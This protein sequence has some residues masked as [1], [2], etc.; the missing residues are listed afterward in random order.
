M[1]G[2][3]RIN[4]AQ[5]RYRWRAVVNIIIFGFPKMWGISGLTEEVFAYGLHGVGLLTYFVTL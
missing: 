5:D 2:V 1:G 4:V 3:G